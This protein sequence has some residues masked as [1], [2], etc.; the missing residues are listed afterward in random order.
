[1]EAWSL[2]AATKASR[3]EVCDL[4]FSLFINTDVSFFLR[5]FVV[6]NCFNLMYCLIYLSPQIWSGRTQ[7]CLGTCRVE[8]YCLSL[9]FA[10]GGRYIVAG[11][12]EGAV[13]VMHLLQLCYYTSV[14]L[15]FVLCCTCHPY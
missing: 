7:L 11:T 10:P 15:H 12:K 3:Y 13:Q 14:L 6:I 1:M 2:L 5:V 8:G 9:A 4:C